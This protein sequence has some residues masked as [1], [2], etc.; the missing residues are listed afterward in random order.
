MDTSQGQLWKDQLSE[1]EIIAMQNTLE[2]VLC[3]TPWVFL[4]LLEQYS[5][6]RFTV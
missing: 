5:M 6:Y 2:T 1:G 3:E 4:Q